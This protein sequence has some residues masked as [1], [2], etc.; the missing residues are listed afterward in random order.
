MT[1]PLTL[2]V[3]LVRLAQYGGRT[4]TWSTATYNDGTEKGLH[5]IALALAAE[6][7]RLRTELAGREDHVQFLR[8]TAIP[9]LRRKWQSE[10]D[11]KKRWRDRAKA[12]EASPLNRFTA[13][14]TEVDDHLRRRLCEDTYLTYQQAIGARVVAEAGSED[15]CCGRYPAVLLCSRHDG[16]GPCPGAPWCTPRDDEEAK[17]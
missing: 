16:F 12:A 6:V 14:P 17:S 1:Q 2:E 13:T 4:S 8:K 7:D 10:K 5:E 11:G 15:S 9:E 3:A